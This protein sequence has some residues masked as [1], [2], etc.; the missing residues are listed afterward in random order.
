MSLF[1]KIKTI[2]EFY[3]SLSI[4]H[5]YYDTIMGTRAKGDFEKEKKLICQAENE[6]SNYSFERINSE[7]NVIGAENIPKEGPIVIIANHQ[8][9]G[10][11]PA[12]MKAIPNLQIGFI[13]KSFIKNVPVFGKSIDMIRGLY[14]ER[15]NTRAAVKLFK[16][17]CDLLNQGFNL[18]I[19]P[20]GT[21]SQCDE[22]GEFKPGS[23]KLATK[24]GAP[25][26]PITI[27]G[28]YKLYER[29]KRL[30]SGTVNLIIHKPVPTKGLN[31]KEQAELVHQVRNTISEGFKNKNRKDF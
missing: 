2:W 18:V 1:Q 22:M 10:D 29:Q 19:F 15:G 26:L 17:G 20:E 28:T 5:K 27:D 4:L 9:Y 25:I 6:W 12:I 7:V 31:R 30:C 14:I 16:E 11:I 8:G 23:F 21:R 13:A 3:S 24:S